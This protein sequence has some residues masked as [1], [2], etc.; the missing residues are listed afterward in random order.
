MFQLTQ[1][2][3][4]ALSAY[5]E[6]MSRQVPL[7]LRDERVAPARVA[8]LR[9][10]IRFRH[11]RARAGSKRNRRGVGKDAGDDPLRAELATPALPAMS[12]PPEPGGAA[13]AT[14][15]KS[16]LSPPRTRAHA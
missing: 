3:R 6:R 14:K 8:D 7:A 15:I 10:A 13:R 12:D 1:S 4:P 11:M 2:W 9:V 5:M 16:S